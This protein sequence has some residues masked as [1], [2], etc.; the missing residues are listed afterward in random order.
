MKVRVSLIP[1]LFLAGAINTWSQSG[2]VADQ[3][4]LKDAASQGIPLQKP[5]VPASISVDAVLL[6][7]R[8]CGRLFGKEI[9]NNYAA[10]ELTVSNSNQDASFLVH[11]VVLDYTDWLIGLSGSSRGAP[12]SK[13]S[14]SSKEAAPINVAD[15]FHSSNKPN[16]VAS[17]EYRIARGEAQDAQQWNSRNWTMRSLV[18]LGVLATGA[19]FAFKE[20]GIIKAI[21]AFTGQGVPGAAAFWPDGVPPQLDRISDF[22]YRA[23]KVIPKASSDIIVAFFPIDRFVTPG[24]KKL[25]LKSPSL[26]FLPALGALDPD[27]PPKFKKILNTLNGGQ[28]VTPSD[29]RNPQKMETLNKASMNQIRITVGGVMAV[30]V[31]TVPARIDSVTIDGTPDWTNPGMAITGVIHG[32]LLT[33]GQPKIDTPKDSNLTLTPTAVPD[34]STDTDLHFSLTVPSTGVPACTPLK[35]TV[36]KT[37][38][39]KDVTSNK[40]SFVTPAAS[41]S[42]CPSGGD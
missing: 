35:F 9:A 22:G 32:T 28:D 4:K 42:T 31:D 40:M 33:N 38:D 25:Y 26:F 16:Q 1:V 34:G 29:L 10:V 30:D 7:A 2:N 24:L 12:E 19:D 6:P 21:T 11:S 8:V 41:G 23:N 39:G 18:L 13:N 17:V 20:Q 36:T 27:T 37:K 15:A 3:Q 5:T 14:T